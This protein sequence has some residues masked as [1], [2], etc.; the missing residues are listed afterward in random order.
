[1]TSRA[2]TAISAGVLSIAL[3]GDAELDEGNVTPEKPDKRKKVFV[4]CV[5]LN[6]LLVYQYKNQMSKNYLASQFPITLQ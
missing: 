4:C 6:N 1:M 2:P 3:V 5:L